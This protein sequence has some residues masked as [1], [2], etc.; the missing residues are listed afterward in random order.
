MNCRLCKNTEATKI[1]SATNMHGRHLW[2]ASQHFDVT[3][4]LSCGAVYID[5]LSIDDDYYRKYYPA[6]YYDEGK[7][8]GFL[9]FVLGALTHI[10]LKSKERTILR[11]LNDRPG[12]SFKILDIGCGQGD[13]LESLN[14]NKFEKFGIE[15]N[16][17]A[18]Q[19]CLKKKLHV[20]DQDLKKADFKDDFF[21]VITLWHVVEHLMD[22]VETLIAAKRILKKDGILVIATPNTDSLGFKLGKKLWFHLDAPRHL[23][24]FGRQSIKFLANAAGLKVAGSGATFYDYP[25]DLFWSLRES[26]CKIPAYILYPFFKMLSQETMMLIFR[27]L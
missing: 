9:G 17:K 14:K 15:I 21:D 27:K 11:Y 18:Y 22:P 8:S 3:R 7:I 20:Y 16:K 5:N 2:D 12:K 26:A 23:T 6:C 4:C 25:L 19:E 24:L 13:F 1:F 10:S